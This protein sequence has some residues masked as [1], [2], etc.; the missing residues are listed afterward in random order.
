MAGGVRIGVYAP[1]KDTGQM[2]YPE[3][4]IG[5][6]GAP[7]NEEEYVD[8]DGEER[9]RCGCFQ[10]SRRRYKERRAEWAMDREEDR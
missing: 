8:E 3:P 5:D 1:G 10:C 6:C 2:T 7:W 4:S 9:V